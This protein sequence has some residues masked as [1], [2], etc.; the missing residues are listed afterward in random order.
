M[1]NIQ[2]EQITSNDFKRGLFKK[3]ECI[4]VDKTFYYI[5]INKEE[6]KIIKDAGD[7]DFIIYD[8]FKNAYVLIDAVYISIYKDKDN[9][10][11]KYSPDTIQK[12]EEI[13]NYHKKL[14]KY[15]K[16]NN[17]SNN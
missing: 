14:K 13:K 1:N 8:L 17:T 6:E 4:I 11:N 12:I 10:Y 9:I 15:D 3:G 2:Y 16:H 5:F 7:G